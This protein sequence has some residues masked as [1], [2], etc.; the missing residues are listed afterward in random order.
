MKQIISYVLIGVLVFSLLVGLGFA[1]GKLDNIF[2]KTITKERM[3][4]KRENFEHNKS[5]VHGMV[6][7]LARYK[8]ELARTEDETERKAI[9]NYII[10]NYSNFDGEM[11]ENESLKKFFYNVME[12]RI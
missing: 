3:D 5:Y 9:I 2:L 6:E 10:E 1:T 4:I 7:D 12:G 8:L 11:I